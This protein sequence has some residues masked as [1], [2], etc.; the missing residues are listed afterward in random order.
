MSNQF[1]LRRAEESDYQAIKD[2]IFNSTNDWY[3]KNFK[4]NV[5]GGNSD[6]CSVFIEVYESLDPGCCIL[7]E[8]TKTGNIAGSCFF[9]PRETHLSLGIMNAHPDYF[10]MG[11]AKMIL[12]EIIS[13]ASDKNLPVRLVSSAMNLDSFSLYTRSGFVPQMTFQDMTM[14]IPEDG[15]STDAPEDIHHVRDATLNDVNQI[16][17]LEFELNGIRRAKDYEFF[18]NNDLK[19]WGVSVFESANGKIEGFLCSVNSNGSKMLGPGVMRQ[20]NHAKALIYY[21]LNK[22]Q[23]GNSLVF[24]IPVHQGELVKTLYEWGARN[25]EMHLCQVRGACPPMNGITMPTFMPETG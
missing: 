6:A 23:R 20:C 16:A 12:Q 2:L 15:L 1:K 4:K 21:E 5:F 11:V 17:D 3:Q 25:C 19:Y 9:H 22:R 8:D 18:I 10:G 24:L 14:S 7:A 13:I